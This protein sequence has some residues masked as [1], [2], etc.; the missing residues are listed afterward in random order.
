MSVLRTSVS[1]EPRINELRPWA[2]VHGSDE[3]CNGTTLGGAG[4]VLDALVGQA[5]AIR[6]LRANIQRI[7]QVPVDV[8]VIGET[9]TGKDLVV[10]QLHALSGRPGPLVAMNCGAIPDALF[11]SE[12][13][14]HEAGAF[15][16]ASKDRAGKFEQAHL[17]TLFLDEIDSMPMNQQ[18]KLLRVLETRRVDRVG[19]RGSRQLDLRVVAA[20]QGD[21]EARCKQGLFRL[22]LWHRLNVVALEVAA[23]R[24]RRDDVP[25][26]WHFHVGNACQRYGVAP[27]ELPPADMA[28]LM[29]YP[30]PGNVRELKHAAE[31]FV[32]GL[33]VLPEGATVDPA[34]EGLQGQLARCERELIASTLARHDQRLFPTAAELGISEKTL[35][36][37]MASYQLRA[38]LALQ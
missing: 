3:S 8:M 2:P 31:R 14:G 9:G 23:L 28:R 21:L 27:C 38:N 30:W 29:A 1:H 11:E 18:V 7:A 20:S 13:F 25:A 12:L 4:S 17:G 37:R 6:R 24:E 34:P 19:G 22:D 32:L 10:Q 16:G 26:L 5:P 35:S 15:T 33:K 36:R